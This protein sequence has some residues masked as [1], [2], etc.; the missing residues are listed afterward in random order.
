MSTSLY[1]EPELDAEDYDWDSFAPDPEETEP[2]ANTDDDVDSVEADDDLDAEDELELELDDSEFDWEATIDEEPDTD[3]VIEARVEAAFERMQDSLDRTSPPEPLDSDAVDRDVEDEIDEPELILVPE[4]EL[5]EPEPEAELNL[6][7]DVDEPELILLPDP[8]AEAEEDSTGAAAVQ[9]GTDFVADELGNDPDTRSHEGIALAL[10]D[11]IPDVSD[12]VDEEELWA[13]VDV[14]TETGTELDDAE[15]EIE[16]NGESEPAS[17][18]AWDRDD[19]VGDE[20]DHDLVGYELDDDLALDEADHDLLGYELD[21]DLVSDEADDD[22]VG[23]ELDHDLVGYE[24]DDDLVDERLEE[25]AAFA[26]NSNEW[27]LIGDESVLETDETRWQPD[28]EEVPAVTASAMV[29]D[30]DVIGSD[31]PPLHPEFESLLEDARGPAHARDSRRSP[32][33]MAA[34]FV[35]C[36]L[37]AVLAAAG[38]SHALHHPATAVS[39]MPPKPSP[40][41]VRLQAA[42]VEADSATTTALSELASLPSF[43]TPTNVAAVVNP[44]VASLRIYRTYLSGVTPPPDA[45]AASAAA[46]RQLQSD[47]SFFSTVDGLPPIELGAYLGQFVSDTGQLQATLGTLERDL[48]GPPPS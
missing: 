37:L 48:G 23:Y 45:H 29:G 26:M 44:Y 22:L 43:P 38:I 35:G 27:E 3:P 1:G 16:A 5:P 42:T 33:L 46:L 24:L 25:G 34:A 14:D 30:G 31:S 15:E 6:E 17:V 9:G 19:L 28:T 47:I 7:A 40:E 8:D 2:G 41:T 36:L 11:G 20:T 18:A 32:V 39:G 12:D 21:D 13:L 10:E 4:S